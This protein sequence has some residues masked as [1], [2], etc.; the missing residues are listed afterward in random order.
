MVQHH[1]G[2][3]YQYRATLL[4]KTI[5]VHDERIRA[6]CPGIEALLPYIDS[7]LPQVL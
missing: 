1:N 5:A 2:F 3:C 4:D 7:M 6:G